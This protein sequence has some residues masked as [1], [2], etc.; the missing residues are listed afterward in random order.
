MSKAIEAFGPTWGKGQT[1]AASTSTA[2]VVIDA[3]GK[4][5]NLVVTN[6]DASILVYVATGSSSVTASTADY[7]VLPGTQVTMSK[8]LDHTHF[9]TISASGTPSI[10]VIPGRG[11]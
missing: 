10:H 2:N 4:Q 5:E 11:L 9:A 1:I 7:L 6:K 3:S 8:N